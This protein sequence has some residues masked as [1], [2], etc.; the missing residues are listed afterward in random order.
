VLL[1]EIQGASGARK[2][3]NKL[4]C[5]TLIT[6]GPPRGRRAKTETTIQHNEAQSESTALVPCG[7]LDEYTSWTTAY[8]CHYCEAI[9]DTS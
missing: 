4:K 6:R 5:L 7:G 3:G 1:E 2:L 8:R 9:S